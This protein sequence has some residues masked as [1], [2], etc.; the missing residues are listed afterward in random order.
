M[1][2]TRQMNLENLKARIV[3]SDYVVDVDAVAEAMVRRLG[4]VF[5]AGQPALGA[6]GGEAG[7][8]FTGDDLPHPNEL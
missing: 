7:A 4:G 6:G 8:R 1:E 2:A 5:V 3:R